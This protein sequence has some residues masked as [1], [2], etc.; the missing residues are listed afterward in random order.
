MTIARKTLKNGFSMPIFGKGTWM[1]NIGRKPHASLK[2]DARIDELKRA[3]DNGITYID[4]AERYS[5]GYGE[6]LIG[7]VIKG[8]NREKLFLVS[9]VSSDHL[10]YDDVI[11]AVKLSLK[12]LQT[13]Y[14]DLYLI[15]QFNPDISLQETMR[16]M[17]FLLEKKLI[18]YIGVCD[19][20]IEQL[21]EAQSY[22]KNA[23]V[24]NQIHYNIMFREPEENG[25]VSYCQKNDVMIIA[26]RPFQ[27]SLL[28]KNTKTFL[29][30]MASKYKK[31]SSQIANMWLMSQ[32]NTVV[33]SKLNT[34]KDI[35]N[36][37]DA[38]SI[39]M[40]SED[41]EKCNKENN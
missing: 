31:T 24:A 6:T 38:C 14:I 19:F 26:W 18:K 29:S 17:D 3:I 1:T 41:R 28:T 7:K 9:K 35:E 4:T 10:A 13:A 12:R 21:K 37:L 8:H 39:E 5:N 25:I 2:D 15:H 22:T 34:N 33:L 20:T 32:P 27:E 23:I 16:A 40:T 11:T 30:E 36:I